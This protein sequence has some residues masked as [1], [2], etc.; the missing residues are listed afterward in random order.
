MCAGKT[1]SHRK[2][3]FLVREVLNFELIG[4]I[5]IYRNNFYYVSL[6]WGNIFKYIENNEW[7]FY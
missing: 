2:F 4:S 1:I 6:Y 3:E 7:S 5:Y